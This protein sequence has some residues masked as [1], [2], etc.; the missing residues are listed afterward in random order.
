MIRESKAG[1]SDLIVE[2][3]EEDIIEE[4][5]IHINASEND[6]IRKAGKDK[7]MQHL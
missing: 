1:Q 7:Q 4:N 5:N 3:G 6:F 2:N